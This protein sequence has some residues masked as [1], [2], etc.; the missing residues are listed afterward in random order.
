MNDE[1][2]KGVD[3]EALK[4]KLSEMSPEELQEFALKEAKARKDQEGFNQKLK[5]EIEA[6]KEPEVKEEEPKLDPVVPV[7][8]TINGPDPYAVAAL[9]AKGYSKQEIEAANSLVGTSF[10]GDVLAV[11]ESAGFQAQ[12]NK[13]REVSKSSE[14]QISDLS[15]LQAPTTDDQFLVQVKNGMIDLSNKTHEDRYKKL[16]T[17]QMRIS[18]R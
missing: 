2:K 9:V 18:R 6:K 12:L 16:L 14:M 15:G 13:D 1:E 8:S 17:R 10:G 7:T 11:A 4:T 5:A 3:L